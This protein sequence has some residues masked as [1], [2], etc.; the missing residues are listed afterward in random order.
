LFFR[1]YNFKD[2]YFQS[3]HII[4]EFQQ[5]QD[6][7]D[8]TAAEELAILEAADDTAATEPTTF[9][10]SLQSMLVFLELGNRYRLLNCL[11]GLRPRHVIMYSQ[12]IAATRAV[13]VFCFPI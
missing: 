3:I 1:L 12:D 5:Q 9:N 11:E 8:A 10:K 4:D 13:E 2:C 7:L 6:A